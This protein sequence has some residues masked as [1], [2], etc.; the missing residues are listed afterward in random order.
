MSLIK[1]ENIVI[2]IGEYEKD[3]QTKKRYKAIGELVTM[4]GDDGSPYQFGTLWGAG[5]A[6]EIKIFDDN[7]QNQNNQSQPQQ[8]YQQPQQGYNQ[9]Q[10]PQQGYKQP[11]NGYPQR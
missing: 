4:M 7:N 6:T 5:G 2:V 8:G 3:G 10:P 1:K 11:Q 9:N